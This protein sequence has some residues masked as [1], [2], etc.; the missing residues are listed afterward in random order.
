MDTPATSAMRFVVASSNPCASRT[1]AVASVIASTVARDLD[2]V[3]NLRG[4][5]SVFCTM[6]VVSANQ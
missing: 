6:A 1:R 2:C 4:C 5:V 3:G